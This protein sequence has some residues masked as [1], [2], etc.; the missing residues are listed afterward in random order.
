MLEDLM[1]ELAK[2][3]DPSRIQ[4][5]PQVTD[6]NRALAIPYADARAYQDRLNEVAG[7]HWSDDYAVLDD[8]AVVLCRLT[9]CGVTR[10]DIGEAPK[11][12]Q[13]TATSAL[14][15][16]FKRA[17][18]KFGVGRY[19][20][21]LPKAW[22]DY[23]PQRKRL[24]RKAGR[25]LRAGL[26]AQISE[27]PETQVEPKGRPPETKEAPAKGVTSKGSNSEATPT[28]FWT[29]YNGHK[30]K[31]SKEQAQEWA[32]TGNWAYALEQLKAALN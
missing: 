22:V 8:G 6:G 11:G 1:D 3:F 31:V 16:A 21:D 26:A 7:A 13:N 20:Y 9:I 10:S 29:L 15:Q 30:G 24:T 2:P 32:T 23:D 25:S 28:V 5:K 14:V 17:C 27:S 4:W 12:D 18:V 19:I